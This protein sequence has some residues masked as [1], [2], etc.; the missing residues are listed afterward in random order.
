M[1]SS[2]IVSVPFYKFPATSRSQRIID[3]H[4]RPRIIELKNEILMISTKT[5][6]KQIVF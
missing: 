6:L 5:N 1:A 4:R 3:F 2:Q